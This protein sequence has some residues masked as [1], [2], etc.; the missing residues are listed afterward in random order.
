MH[1]RSEVKLNGEKNRAAAFGISIFVIGTIVGLL[2]G[3]KE[4]RDQLNVK[5]KQLLNNLSKV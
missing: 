2:V 4:I 3:S 5:S 1:Q